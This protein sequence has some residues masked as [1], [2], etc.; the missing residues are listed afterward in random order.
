M[1][2]QRSLDSTTAPTRRGQACFVRFSGHA[3]RCCCL[4]LGLLAAASGCFRPAPPKLNLERPEPL[5]PTLDLK[6]YLEASR[7]G[8]WVYERTDLRSND[9]QAPARYVRRITEGRMSE[10]ILS[11]RPLPPLERYLHPGDGRRSTTQPAPAPPPPLSTREAPHFFELAEPMPVIPPD[12][13][14]MKPVST[15]TALRYYGRRGRFEMTGTLTRSVHL[16]GTQ[17]V[18]VPAGN[19]TDC[20]RLRVELRIAFPLG[21]TIDWN[22]YVWLSREAGE[23]RRIDEFSGTFWV[24]GFGSAHEYRLASYSRAEPSGGSTASP[25][26]LWRRGLITLDRPIPRPRISGMIVDFAASHPKE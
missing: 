11:H 8:E 24:F 5:T 6:A 3:A 22:S 14:P 12:L 23:V 25:A 20:L 21:P 13:V 1:G 10:G 15:T 17:D 9:D 7:R 19:F 16:E 26:P 18:E 4:A 2:C